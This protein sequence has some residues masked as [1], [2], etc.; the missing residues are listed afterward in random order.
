M[1]VT[2][3][4]RDEE[5]PKLFG[6][7]PG[8]LFRPLAGRNRAVYVEVLIA[9]HTVMGDDADE[10]DLNRDDVQRIIGDTL[11]MIGVAELEDEED[12]E[13]DLRSAKGKDND[14]PA[15]RIYSR[16]R[17]C[18]WLVEE[19]VGYTYR[20]SMPF[21]VADLLAALC[22]IRTNQN[23]RYGVRV[24]GIFNQMRTAVKLDE[25][26]AAAALVGA[27]RESV[28]FGRHLR[29]MA[30]DVKSVADIASSL[31]D[32]K[33]VMR[34]FFKDFVEG[35]LVADW[36][37]LKTSHNPFRY[38][39]DVLAL[40]STVTYSSTVREH[41][42]RSLLSMD[43]RS[44]D[45]MPAALVEIDRMAH[46][47]ERVFNRIS[48]RLARIDL[49]RARLEAK[50]RNLVLYSNTSTP[51]IAGQLD[52][53]IRGLMKVPPATLERLDI[54]SIVPL[55]TGHAL[56]PF[57]LAIPRAKRKPIA[58]RTFRKNVRDMREALRRR[59]LIGEYIGRIKPSAEVIRD[60]LSKVTLDRNF[61]DAQ[62]LPMDDV[63]SLILFLVVEQLRPAGLVARRT[64]KGFEM[65][66]LEGRF[67]NDLL[68][69]PS[70]R[71]RR[72]GGYDAD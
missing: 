13:L 59:E 58:P 19:R 18:G 56:S 31:T 61:V 9:L 16:L 68:N 34:V 49:N 46:Q 14:T 11:R 40:V 28:E 62:D 33:D 42:A 41:L 48:E 5:A 43:G 51:G 32:Q 39:A 63:D 50:A 2:H 4:F 47:I 21:A 25:P 29:Q 70:F 24:F 71:I 3:P 69:V 23:E 66:R 36:A 37:L 15:S 20:A 64:L 54:G 38:R 45:Q 6:A 67:E 60:Y 65:V 35:F 72:M 27:A 26:H 30:N 12:D 10:D 1:A 17:A 55:S 52:S 22:R 7:L 44:I 53:L 8:L 57:T